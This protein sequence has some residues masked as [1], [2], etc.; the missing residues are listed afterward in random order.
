MVPQKKPL[1][2]AHAL[3]YK[4]LKA[5]GGNDSKIDVV[6]GNIQISFFVGSAIAAK[7]TPEREETSKRRLGCYCSNLYS[8]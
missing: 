8:F 6:H 2:K 1:A 7:Y 5:M 4:G 3:F